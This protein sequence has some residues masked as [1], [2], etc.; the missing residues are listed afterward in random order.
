MVVLDRRH[1]ERRV[2][3]WRMSLLDIS[4]SLSMTLAES[5]SPSLK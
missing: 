3:T 4:N 1:V 5:E 2:M